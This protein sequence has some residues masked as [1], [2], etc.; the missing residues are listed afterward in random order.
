MG[1]SD[2]FNPVFFMD[3]DVILITINY[4]LGLFGFLSTGDD[5][6]PGNNGLKDMVL[7]LKWIQQSVSPFGGDSSKVTIFGESAG[8]VAVQYLMLSP[9]TKGL[10]HRAISQS[11]SALSFWGYNPNP[12]KSTLEFISS[13]DCQTTA[14]NAM[15]IS[16]QEIA[17]CLKRFSNEELIKALGKV[18]PSWPPRSNLQFLFVPSCEPS[19]PVSEL[20]PFLA[21]PPISILTNAS[22]SLPEI[23]YM[24]GATEAEGNVM[25]AGVVL[26]DP[27]LIDELN[28]NWETLA[29]TT[30]D[31]KSYLPEEERKLVANKIR[32]FYFGDQD[33][34]EANAATLIDL[35]SDNFMLHGIYRSAVETARKS[36]RNPVYFYQYDYKGPIS[37]TGY[38]MQVKGE[39]TE[40]KL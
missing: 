39:A 7:A 12:R 27:N 36:K 29:P 10:Y 15:D 19:E 38:F 37:L 22:H 20:T 4:R 21:E 8:G 3:E 14:Q 26:S 25:W 40:S 17:D 16:S 35:Y 31:F 30:F 32:Q 33:I 13:L 2:Q 28:K 34:S 11:G 24:T 18:A 23:P 5:V 1:S 9:T 6:I